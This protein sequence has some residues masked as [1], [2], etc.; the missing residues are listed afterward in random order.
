MD[1][2]E[3]TSETDGEGGEGGAEVSPAQ[4]EL[5][6][7]RA[8]LEGADGEGEAAAKEPPAKGDK[9]PEKKPDPAEKA[10]T[11]G[12][13]WRKV[14]AKAKALDY[15]EAELAKREAS[16][17]ATGKELEGLKAKAALWER[18]QKGDAD[19]LEEAGLDYEA[20][21]DAVL[22]RKSG[23]SDA[24]RLAAKVEELEARLK[25]RDDDSEAERAKASEERVY[26]RALAE[27]SDEAG[28]HK[29][30]AKLE[31]KKPGA[32][33]KM[34]NAL[35]LRLQRAE[36]AVPAPAELARRLA[37]EVQ[38]ELDEAAALRAE[39]EEGDEAEQEKPAPK[40]APSIS[41]ADKGQRGGPP[42]RRIPTPEEERA[43]IAASLRG[44]A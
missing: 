20:L 23:K 24:A 19:A 8:S 27:F 21:T 41:R 37:K 43:E 5:D 1:E 12:A 11:L 31:A 26:Q 4:A 15:R 39:L 42:R 16:L 38:A 3:I 40:P 2:T 33:E 9:E 7:I 10:E 22:Q 25:K 14:R 13:S 17:G 30:L 29:A 6:E 44:G 36:G 35:A 34:G 18:I 28:K 32:L